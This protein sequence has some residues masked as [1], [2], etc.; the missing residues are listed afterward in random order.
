MKT[1]NRTAIT[2]IPKQPYIDWANSFEDAEKY[3][4][5]HATTIKTNRQRYKVEKRNRINDFRKV[6]KI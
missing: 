1:I 6:W 2:V 3:D 4:T 5:P